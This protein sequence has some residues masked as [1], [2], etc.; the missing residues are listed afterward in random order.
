MTYE[1]SL[2]LIRKAPE[3]GIILDAGCGDLYYTK[4]LKNNL[5]NIISFD[6]T[7][8]EKP[9]NNEILFFLGTIENLPFKNNTFDF[10]YC[11]SVIQ[12]IKNDQSVINEFFRVLKPGGTLLLTVPTS[13]SPFR[14]IREMEIHFNV[15]Q[16]PQYNVQHHHY[17]SLK[18]VQKL[19]TNS[20]RIQSISGYKYNFI[21][22]LVHFILEVS[23]QKK[24]FSGTMKFFS[25]G[26]NETLYH[27][28]KYHI[29]EYPIIDYD[30][31]IRKCYRFRLMANLFDRLAYHYIILLKKG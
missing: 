14:I 21:P 22:R 13:K 26:K 12:L 3:A 6:I 30:L 25:E 11:F 1:P 15:Y 4:I 24:W 8:P 7:E 9:L 16:T 29:I 2:S 27:N 17:Y 20:F 19:A 5:R 23:K 18:D 10:I 31:K 28:Y